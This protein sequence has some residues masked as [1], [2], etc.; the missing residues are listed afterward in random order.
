MS[1]KS[2]VFKMRCQVTSKTTHEV[3]IS[4]EISYKSYNEICIWEPKKVN[5]GFNTKAYF[6]VKNNSLVH[7]PRS[8]DNSIHGKHSNIIFDWELLSK[9]FSIHNIEPNWLDCEDS[10][11]HYDDELGGWTGC[12]GKV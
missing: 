6:Q 1:S 8:L 7:I 11:G 2:F 10:F 12:V 4:K 5:L 9:F 3:L